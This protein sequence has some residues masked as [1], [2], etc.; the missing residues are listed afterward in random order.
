[1]CAWGHF[2]NAHKLV[3]LRTLK[4]SLLNTLH[5]FQYMGKIFC[6]ELWNSTQNVSPIHWRIRFLYH[7]EYLR[8]LRFMSSKLFFKSPLD[9]IYI[10]V[11][12]LETSLKHFNTNHNL[13]CDSNYY[14]THNWWSSIHKW[15]VIHFLVAV[16]LPKMDIYSLNV[17]FCTDLQEASVIISS[18]DS[19]EATDGLGTND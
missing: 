1:M 14:E 4:F 10:C 6:V 8:T 11:Y 17:I 5:I 19:T 2:K 3:N 13:I 18:W 12:L 7:V 15:F 9:L 16:L